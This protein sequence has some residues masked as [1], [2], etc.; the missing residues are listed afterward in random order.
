[1]ESAHIDEH[2]TSVGLGLK[3]ELL[4]LENLH[5]EGI[6]PPPYFRTQDG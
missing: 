5:Y 6:K 1:M 4:N 3:N 2:H